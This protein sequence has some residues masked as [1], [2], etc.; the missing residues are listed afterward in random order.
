MWAIVSDEKRI[1]LGQITGAHGIR[2]EI[3]IRAHTEAPE[4]IIAYGPLE[5]EAGDRRFALSKVRAT[6]G[7]IIARVDG[8]GD[9]NQA[10][11]LKGALLYVDRDRLPDQEDGTWYHADLIGLVAL[12]SQGSALG[13][14]VAVQN[15]GAGDLLEVRPNDGGS[16][17]LIPFT[18]EVVPDIDLANGRLIVMP[19]EGLFEE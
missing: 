15:Y 11:A 10:E 6:K 17:V 18:E 3:R 4:D 8:V 19:P 9:R 13:E 14:V 5:S 16:T 7:G 1:C 12:D 2:G